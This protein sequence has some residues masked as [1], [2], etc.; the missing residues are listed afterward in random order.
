M[1]KLDALTL[2]QLR[3]LGAVSRLGSITAAA[4]TLGLTPP[5][6]HTQ[7]RGLETA[8]GCKVLASSGAGGAVLTPEGDAVLRANA[9]IEN[10]LAA[11]VERVRASSSR[12]VS[13]GVSCTASAMRACAASMS[14]RLTGSG[15]WSAVIDRACP[16]WPAIVA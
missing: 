5:A 8:L 4:E 1:P 7:L 10:A 14:A 15:C 13:T 9:Q 11:C 3:A 6:V 16:G 2:K 12:L